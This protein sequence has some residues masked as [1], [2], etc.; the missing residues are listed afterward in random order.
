M[1]VLSQGGV[2]FVRFTVIDGDIGGAPTDNDPSHSRIFDRPYSERAE[3]RMDGTMQRNSVYEIS[4]EVRFP[5]RDGKNKPMDNYRK[6]L[7]SAVERS[8]VERYGKP[9][10][11]TPKY[12][13]KAFT[14]YQYLRG[15]PQSTIKKLVGHSPNSRVTEAHYLHIPESSLRNT[16]FELEIPENAE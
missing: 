9:I 1:Q 7:K 15:V 12:A 8:G 3:V 11:F 10:T 14:S 4:F 2:P 16:V 5:N 13:R 6:S